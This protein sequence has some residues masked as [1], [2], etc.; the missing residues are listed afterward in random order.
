MKLKNKLLFL[1][2]DGTVEY[3]FESDIKEE[4]IPHKAIGGLKNITKFYSVSAC[5][6]TEGYRECVP[7]TFAQALTGELYDLSNFQY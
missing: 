2:A 1:L 4:T 5:S 6:E 7:D 3:V